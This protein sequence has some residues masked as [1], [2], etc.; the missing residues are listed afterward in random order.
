MTD[1]HN[2][3]SAGSAPVLT[4]RL[5]QAAVDYEQGRCS[6]REL[7]EARAAVEA[8]I[9]ADAQSVGVQAAL[10]FDVEDYVRDYEFRGEGGD[11]KPTEAEQEVL[12]DAIHGVLA[13]LFDKP[14]KPP[15]ATV[16]LHCL[17]CGAT[18]DVGILCQRCRKPL[19]RCSAGNGD[20]EA[21]AV[22]LHSALSSL[23]ESYLDLRKDTNSEPTFESENDP[24]KRAERALF[25][26]RPLADWETSAATLNEPQAALD[27]V[28]AHAAAQAIVD[29]TDNNLSMLDACDGPTAK[30]Q[31]LFEQAK[32]L[33]DRLALSLPR[34]QSRSGE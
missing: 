20:A 29:Y 17:Q 33:R 27:R 11:Y 18:D 12:I 5:I 22:N 15:A 21:K 10:D 7:A 28:S 31:E 26:N 16:D 25:D 13:A 1:S 14:A 3:C 32:A 2:A 23:L 34:P 24:D 9:P 4:E 6:S 30:A 19:S 8:A